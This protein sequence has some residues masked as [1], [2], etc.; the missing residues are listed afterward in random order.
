MMVP[1]VFVYNGGHY[2]HTLVHRHTRICMRAYIYT[3]TCACTH[4]RTYVISGTPEPRS[5]LTHGFRLPLQGTFTKQLLPAPSTP[6]PSS[7][8]LV[9]A[10]GSL[11]VSGDAEQSHEF[12][13]PS[14]T[15]LK[16]QTSQLEEPCSPGI[17]LPL[18][19]PRHRGTLHHAHILM[20]T[21]CTQ[22]EFLS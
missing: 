22:V 17:R 13:T 8:L 9:L 10:A 4:T 21:L 3:H 11:V 18:Q 15:P 16:A 19:Q 5:S 2:T 6:A 1:Y 12:S 7:L 20:R 14:V